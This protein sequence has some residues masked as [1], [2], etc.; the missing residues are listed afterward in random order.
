[1][2]T[3][4]VIMLVILGVS[5]FL[6]FLKGFAWQ[7]ASVAAFVVSYFVAVSFNGVVADYFGMNDFVA[8][9]LLF[10]GTSLAVWIGYGIIHKQIEQFH[11]KSFD[12]QIGAVVGLGTGV[13]LC[14]VV[15]FFAVTLGEGMG[16]K[17]VKS[18]SGKYIAQVIHKLD[19]ILP[20]EMQNKVGPYLEK[21]DTELNNAQQSVE[22]NP[23]LGDD[24]N[25]A[26]TFSE[27]L[28]DEEKWLREME[29]RVKEL[30]N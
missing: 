12:R 10:I 18:N 19:G 2:Q 21:L 17:V 24:K 1:M 29:A 28:S 26:E 16:R 6:G 11:L 30:G 14:L 3:Y 5:V 22:Q 4:D 13:I 23:T 15:T 7:V 27:S 9:F 20:V 25:L 8:M